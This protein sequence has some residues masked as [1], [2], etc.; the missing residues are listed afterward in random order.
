MILTILFKI[1]STSL[2]FSLLGYIANAVY[3]YRTPIFIRKAVYYSYAVTIALG[4][5]LLTSFIWIC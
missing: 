3:E 1:F 5:I 2:V 4:I